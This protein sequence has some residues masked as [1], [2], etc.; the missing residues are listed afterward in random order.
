MFA[1]ME[2]V[3]WTST[4]GG[5]EIEKGGSRWVAWRLMMLYSAAFCVYFR[6]IVS[7]F[8]MGN[9]W[10]GA[11]LEHNENTN[12][13]LSVCKDRRYRF[14]FSFLSLLIGV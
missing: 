4:D 1:L 3:P 8:I 11:G 5:R 14:C 10:P 13:L 2:P 12:P 7:L 6:L 9:G